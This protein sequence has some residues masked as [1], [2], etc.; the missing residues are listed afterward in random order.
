MQSTNWAT[1]VIFSWAHPGMPIIVMV[2]APWGG[3]SHPMVTSFWRCRL[4]NSINSAHGHQLKGLT[5]L[6]RLLSEC[7]STSAEVDAHGEVI[8]TQ[9][10]KF[11]ESRL[12]QCGHTSTSIYACTYT[13]LPIERWTRNSASW[14]GA[15]LIIGPAHVPN[16]IINDVTP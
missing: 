12:S 1:C 4:D 10:V 13:S 2:V 3:K 15:R 8:T 14:C 9:S 5:V 11:E 16:D 7:F 6:W